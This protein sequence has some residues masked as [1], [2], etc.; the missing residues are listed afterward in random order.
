[1]ERLIKLKQDRLQ[2]VDIIDDTFNRIKADV[3]RSSNNQ[4]SATRAIAIAI[5]KKTVGNLYKYPEVDRFAEVPERNHSLDPHVFRPGLR[6]DKLDTNTRELKVN[7]I[8]GYGD[9]TWYSGG[10]RF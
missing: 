7:K 9:P 6:A 2:C 3:R 10:F 1:M 4:C 5:D 8:S